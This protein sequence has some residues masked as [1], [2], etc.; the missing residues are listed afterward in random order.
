MLA[1]DLND[2][3]TRK[4]T[5]EVSEAVENLSDLKDDYLEVEAKESAGEDI[6]E[7]DVNIAQEKVNIE[8]SMFKAVNLMLLVVL[9][10]WITKYI[11]QFVVLSSL[12]VILNMFL[13]TDKKFL[14]KVSEEQGRRC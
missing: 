10:V 1:E 12:L 7:K 14:V 6:L 4:E 5:L 13:E 11:Y 8:R 9:S 3:I 2:K